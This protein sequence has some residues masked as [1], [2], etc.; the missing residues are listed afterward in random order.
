MWRIFCSSLLPAVTPPRPPLFPRTFLLVPTLLSVVLVGLPPAAVLMARPW[1]LLALTPL[2]RGAPLF[3][4]GP[5]TTGSAANTAGPPFTAGLRMRGS[6]GQLFSSTW[7]RSSLVDFSLSLHCFSSSSF[8]S[9]GDLVN[10]AMRLLEPPTLIGLSGGRTSWLSGACAPP[11]PPA[12]RES[13][14]QLVP[15]KLLSTFDLQV[16]LC[17]SNSKQSSMA[18]GRWKAVRS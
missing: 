16:H 15:E 14:T 8:V 6:A 10:V 5:R 12:C 4:A 7:H 1:W 13:A 17:S 18:K 2:P 3:T 9:G 11:P